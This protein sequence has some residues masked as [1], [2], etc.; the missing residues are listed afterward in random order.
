MKISPSSRIKLL[1]DCEPGQL[2]RSPNFEGDDQFGVVF[3][4]RPET[5]PGRYGWIALTGGLPGRVMFWDPA[6]STPVQV[7]DGELRFEIDQFEAVETAGMKLF[8]QPGCIFCDPAG[9]SMY[10]AIYH[11]HGDR[12]MKEVDGL[13][14]LETGDLVTSY[15]G[16]SEAVNFGQWSAYIVDGDGAPADR[17][18]IASFPMSDEVAESVSAH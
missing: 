17:T 7:F 9:W 18:L 10:V 13:L 16:R 11:R 15:V 5:G 1:S 4:H 3:R 12:L 2:I 6:E 14:R 8:R